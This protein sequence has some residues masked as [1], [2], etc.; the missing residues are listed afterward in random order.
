MT[1]NWYK[2]N[3]KQ[4]QTSAWAHPLHHFPNFLFPCVS[5]LSWVKHQQADASQIHLHALTALTAANFG[6][7]HKPLMQDHAMLTQSCFGHHPHRFHNTACLPAI[8]FWQ[9][10]AYCWD[11]Q[12]YLLSVLIVLHACFQLDACPFLQH[13]FAF[14]SLVHPH[15][16]CCPL[17][18]VLETWAYCKGKSSMEESRTPLHIF[19][20]DPTKA[21]M[22][23]CIIFTAFSRILYSCEWQRLMHVLHFQK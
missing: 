16:Y 20:I 2:S 1:G 15:L 3:L 13:H 23:G 19:L 22:I 12:P 9:C 8:L 21:S 14:L 17:V 5:S 7:L 4:H 11:A 10:L 18:K 6:S